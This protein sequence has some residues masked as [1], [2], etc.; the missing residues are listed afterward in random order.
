[1]ENKERI[2]EAY[3]NECVGYLVNLRAEEVIYV[4]GRYQ[5]N[6]IYGKALTTTDIKAL[7][8]VF[9][10]FAMETK[11]CGKGINKGERF[12]PVLRNWRNRIDAVNDKLGGVFS[13][14]DFGSYR[15]SCEVFL[16]DKHL[17][18]VTY[19]M[20]SVFGI[21]KEEEVA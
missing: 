12:V 5:K 13:T 19:K 21:N 17:L 9:N 18:D 20:Y 7:K 8:R 10:S 6:P 11:R 16:D 2:L 3:V 14:Y 4:D 15:Y 1:M